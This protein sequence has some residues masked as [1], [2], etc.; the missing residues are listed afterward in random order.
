MGFGDIASQIIMF[1]A[2]VTVALT[3]VFMLND[4]NQTTQSSLMSKQKLENNKLMTELSIDLID[5]EL[6]ELTVYI[7]NIGE[8]K[9]RLESLFV[10]LDGEFIENSS[11]DKNLVEETD[12][13]DEG[14]FNNNEILKINITKV[15]DASE[16]KLTISLNNGYVKTERFYP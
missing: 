12:I 7:K 1:V 2:I 14:I 13:I 10:Y 3:F 11:I 16:H 5:Y 6:G 9:L 8:T 4:M 15:L